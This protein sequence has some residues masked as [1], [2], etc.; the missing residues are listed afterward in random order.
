MHYKN[1][2]GQN[3][4][5]RTVIPWQRVQKAITSYQTPK[6]FIIEPL[7][8]AENQ[9]V[10]IKGLDHKYDNKLQQSLRVS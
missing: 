1:H 4:S 3:T 7:F 6:P 2:K 5:N 9:L 10:S 8:S